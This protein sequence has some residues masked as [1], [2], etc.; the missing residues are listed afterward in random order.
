MDYKGVIVGLGN[1]GAKYDHT[2]HNCGFDFVSYLVELA[3][4]DGEASQQNG[5][6]FSCELWRLRLPKL[7]GLWLAAKPQTFM[8]LSGQCV[9]PLLAWHKLKPHDLVVVHD[10]LDIPA[11]EL[12]IHSVEFMFRDWLREKYGDIAAVNAALGSA[13]AEFDDIAPPQQAYHFAAFQAMR[14]E[15]RWEFVTRNYR[16]VL[17]YIFFHGRGIANTA[18]YCSLAVL[19]ALLVNPLAAY[20][21]SRYRMPSTYKILLFLMLTM[22]FPPM[23]LGFLSPRGATSRQ[24]QARAGGMMCIMPRMPYVGFSEV[25]NGAR[26]PKLR[27]STSTGSFTTL[28]TIR[29]GMMTR[30]LGQGVPSESSV[31]SQIR[32]VALGTAWMFINRSGSGGWMQ[33]FS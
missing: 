22:A 21:M 20:A 3:A 33:I 9:Q 28:G 25:H 14:G 2:R 17:D 19:F 16:A 10:E 11:G 6:K 23:M 24:S 7:G 1:P 5:G 27:T 29:R 13:Y 8:N 15:L 30:G 31:C 18:I 4:R 26:T 32:Q 12:R